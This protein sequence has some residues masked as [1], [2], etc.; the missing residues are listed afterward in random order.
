[1]I[2]ALLPAPG[3]EPAPDPVPTPTWAL[4]T[5][6]FIGIALVVLWCMKA[7]RWGVKRW[8]LT[9]WMVLAFCF[10]AGPIIS[11]W[12]VRLAGS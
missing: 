4:L 5:G 11:K 3:Q 9:F 7:R 6:S 10:I 2:A 1:M 8:S 12:L